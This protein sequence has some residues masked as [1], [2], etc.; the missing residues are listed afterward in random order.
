[1]TAEILRL[2][3]LVVIG[4]AVATLG[5]I[6]LAWLIYPGELSRGT[7]G[8][9]LA[10]MAIAGACEAGYWIKLEDV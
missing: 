2:A 1:M 10:L 6:F 9:A 4:T 7:L 3:L 8:T 5:S